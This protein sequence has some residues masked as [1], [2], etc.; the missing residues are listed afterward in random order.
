[1]SLTPVINLPQV[2]FAPPNSLLLVSLTPLINIHLRLSLQ[3][4]EKVETILM[5]YS[6]AQGTLFHEK[7]RSCNSFVRLPLN[8]LSHE[9]DFAFDDIYG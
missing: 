5:G 9:M 1:V 8:G 6:G 4:F 2:L 3:I 7:N